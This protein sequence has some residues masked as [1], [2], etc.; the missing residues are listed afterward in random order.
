VFAP[1]AAALSQGVR[2]E[3]FGPEIDNLIEL[4]SL[5][6]TATSDGALEARIIHL[7]RF[8]NC[9]TNLTREHLGDDLS[10]AR[11]RIND[12]E[13]TSFRRYYAEQTESNDEVFG[14]I[15]SAGFLELAATNASAA[16][17]LNA[18]RGDSVTLVA[19]SQ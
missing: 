14:I 2:P 16:T 12:R 9:V 18:R 19:R 11:V 7:D 4:E 3:E 17:V 5:K 8:G 13:I 10:G 1:V 6:P 15:G